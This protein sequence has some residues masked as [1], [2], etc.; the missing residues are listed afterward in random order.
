MKYLFL[1][2]LQI[3]LFYFHLPCKQQLLFSLRREAEQSI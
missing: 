1:S 2:S 3:I